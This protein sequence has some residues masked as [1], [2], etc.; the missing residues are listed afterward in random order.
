MFSLAR[1]LL[2]LLLLVVVVPEVFLSFFLEIE[3]NQRVVRLLFLFI[4]LFI[5]FEF[6][7]S[8][9]C[10][11]RHLGVYCVLPSFSFLYYWVFVFLT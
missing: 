2:L 9:D 5:F 3:K 1:L 8:N 6:V 4:Y 11:G 10:G 7:C